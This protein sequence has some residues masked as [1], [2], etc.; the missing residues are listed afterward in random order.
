MGNS[1]GDFAAI[2]MTIA[3]GDRQTALRLIALAPGIAAESLGRGGD[4]F[5]PVSRLQAYAGHTALHAAAFA[6]DVDV[7][8][9][10]VAAGADV[11]ARNRRG[12]E[13]LHAA[14]MGAPGSAHWNPAAQRKVIAYLVSMGADPNA[15]DVSGITPLHRAVR[16][17][18]S[19]AVEALLG[20][21]ADPRA[22][23]RSGSTPLDVA[24]WTTGR[25]GTG[26]APAKA[27]QQVI[28]DLLTRTS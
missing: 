21:G 16:N 23:N 15:G 17:R 4:F 9:A 27:E 5:D 8:R 14:T 11:R 19:A 1:D 6:Y 3:R 10:L 25:G 13:P 2:L 26:S 20:L 12:A 18:C 24:G 7:A 28:I 22:T